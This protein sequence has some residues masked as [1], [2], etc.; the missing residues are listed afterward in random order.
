MNSSGAFVITWEG[1]GTGDDIGIFAR[2]FN[3]D[4]TANGGEFRAN[5]IATTHIQS[6]SSVAMDSAGD[7]VI[8]WQSHYLDS[9]GPVYST[10]YDINGQRYNSSGVG[11]GD[12]TIKLFDG[13]NMVRSPSVA[14]D[15]SGNFVVTWEGYNEDGG[16][17]G[18]GARKYTSTG[19]AGS[20][21]VANTSTNG[22]QGN[23][24]IAMDSAGNFIVAWKNNPLGTFSIQA[25]KFN[26]DTTKNDSQFIVN[27]NTVSSIGTP[28]VAMDDS[29]HF[30]VIWGGGVSGDTTAILGQRYD[31]TG[32]QGT[33]FMVNAFT[34]N[35]QQ[36]P[37]VAM[38]SN[39]NFNV[40][41]ESLG[42][43]LDNYGIFGHRYDSSGGNL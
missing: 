40:V 35:S 26:P 43:D 28:V 20:I 25:Q 41:W 11:Q 2:R 18:I 8:V 29:G 21:F 32:T 19:T 34:T 10:Y 14:M 37:A 30:S 5:V 17:F 24:S 7:F 38:D 42:Q 13:L 16:G 3:S 39:G 4:G 31:S 22:F 9:I 23:P 1:Q 6:N 36:N 12:I 15:G 27:T 33:E